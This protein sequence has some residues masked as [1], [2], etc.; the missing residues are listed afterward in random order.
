MVNTSTI[1]ENKKNILSIKNFSE[2]NKYD[3]T[4]KNIITEKNVIVDNEEYDNVNIEGNT[5]SISSL[6]NSESELKSSNQKLVNIIDNSKD[7]NINDSKEIIDKNDMEQLQRESE[8]KYS[9]LQGGV[10]IIYNIDYLLED[11]E[12]LI[13][14]EKVIKQ[15]DIYI[16]NYNSP[17]IQKYKQSLKQ[18][19]QKYSNKN[20]IIST[21]I[22]NIKNKNSEND[23]DELNGKLNNIINITKIIVKKNDKTKKVI[24]ELIKPTYF[25]YNK[26]NYIL[27]LKRNISNDRAE[28]LYKYEKLIA[29][30]SITPEDKKIFEKERKHFIK[31]LEDY[32]TYTLYHKKI[33][34]I[35]TL[36]KS[37]LVLQKEISIFKEQDEYESKILSSNIYSVDNSF[38]DTMN[39]Y[40]SENLIQFNNIMQTLNGKKEEEINKDKKIK[41]TIKSYIKNRNEIELFTQSLIKDADI[42]D[43][44]INYVV[45]HLP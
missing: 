24:I 4:K 1:E 21:T 44:Y 17:K 14:F 5:T 35:N 36:N 25:Y 9:L 37:T 31:K 38:I 2:V 18:L 29:K 32:Y 27:S 41:E 16:N 3:E 8:D 13:N 10:D 15:V 19:Y 43:N 6:V 26:D 34:K 20:F 7:D 12:K 39:K 33:N 28:L 40:N 23:D 42:Q 11:D 45:L 22:E 30:L